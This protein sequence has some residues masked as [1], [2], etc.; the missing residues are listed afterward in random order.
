MKFER[1][2]NDKSSS[3]P[4]C[5]EEKIKDGNGKNAAVNLTTEANRTLIDHRVCFDENS[6]LRN[7]LSF[8]K[9]SYA[10]ILKQPIRTVRPRSAP[11]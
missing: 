3:K 8:P 10:T 2:I 1:L 9:V 5:K 6:N 11:V 4:K 7:S